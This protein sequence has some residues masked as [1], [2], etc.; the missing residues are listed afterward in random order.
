MNKIYYKN[1]IIFLILNGIL[2]LSIILINYYGDGGN[3]FFH[4][5]V[6]EDKLVKALLSDKNVLVCS[7]YNDRNVKKLLLKNISTPRDVLI[8]G[9]S[10]TMLLRQDLFDNSSFFNNSVTTASLE[11]DIAL[12]YLYQQRGWKPKKIVIGLDPWIIIDNPDAVLW[13]EDFLNEYNNAVQSFFGGRKQLLYSY[14]HINAILEKNK[15]LL[16]LGY[17]KDSIK[18][19]KFLQNIAL[20]RSNSNNIIIEPTPDQLNFFSTCHLYQSDG[21]R[22]TS[23]AEELTSS[24]QADYAGS[25]EAHHLSVMSLSYKRMHTFEQFIDYLS[26]QG[27]EVVFYFPPYEPE[28]YHE[29]EKAINY[30][31]IMQIDKYFHSVAS[32]YHIKSLGSYNPFALHLTANDFV[33]DVHLKKQGIDKLF[34][35]V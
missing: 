11:D 21:V 5:A 7:N 8:F 13:K 17:L 19:L 4:S 22:L 27:I 28:A 15:Q 25:V 10:R 16:S 2:L 14:Q 35:T 6:F 24:A 1:L 3:R 9:S 30:Q 18:N 31:M 23:N 12:Y 20:F 33:D 26:K 34:K 29:I 32:R